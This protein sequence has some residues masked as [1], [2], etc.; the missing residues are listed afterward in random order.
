MDFR[1]KKHYNLYYL[2]LGV[3]LFRMAI[4]PYFGLGV[5]EA[6]YALY[7]ENLALSYF[8]HPPLVGWVQA[9]FTSIFGVNEFAIRLTAIIIGAVVNLSVYILIFKISQSSKTAFISTLALNAS[10]LFNALFLMLMPDTLLFVLLI[11]IIFQTL[12]LEDEATLKNFLILAFL[13]GLAGLAKY[14]AVLF[15]VAIVI[16]FLIKK[17]YNILFNIKIVPAIILSAIMILPIIIW[18]IQNEWISFAFQSSHVVA[19]KSIDLNVFFS[20]IGAQLGAYNPF[21]F[22]L[23]YF[24]LYKSLRSTNRYLFISAIFALVLISFFTYASLYSRALP[25]W[26][27]LFYMLMIPIGTY[28]ALELKWTKYLKYS[29]GF[30]LIVS[31]ILYLELALK[32]IPLPHYQSLHRDIHGYERIMNEANRLISDPTK[33]AFA[34]TNWS[35]A[36]RALFY[37]RAYKS[38]VYLIDDR[39]DQFDIWQNGSPNGKD[40]LFI[41]THFF[42]VNVD[43]LKCKSVEK[44]KEFDILLNNNKVN[45]I[46]L[47]WCKGYNKNENR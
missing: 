4:A 20:S 25:H 31:A 9:V 8:D 21:L 24:G 14:T 5:D 36:S 13:L 40:L 7:G 46:S 43:N 15:V 18:N 6:H 37:N 47:I 10:F 11:P 16:Y 2:I 1:D 44:A 29:I 45:T 27:A 35:I 23:A 33:E 3:T 30:G 34:V 41:N 32:F 38:N 12:K 22:I 42:N 28:Y 26:S 17:R 19:D 39:Y